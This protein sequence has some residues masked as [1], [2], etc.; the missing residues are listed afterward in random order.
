MWQLHVQV[1][2]KLSNCFKVGALFAFPLVHENFTALPMILS[3]NSSQPNI[4]AWFL[5]VIR[6]YISP[7]T[8]DMERLFMF[9]ISCILCWFPILYFKRKCFKILMGSNQKNF[10]NSFTMD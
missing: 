3:F 1:L 6:I 4:H 9:D 7:R 8:N 2:K 5:T 10:I